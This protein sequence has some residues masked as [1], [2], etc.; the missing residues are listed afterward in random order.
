MYPINEKRKNRDV[1]H[2]TSYPLLNP[3]GP[4]SDQY[5]YVAK[6]NGYES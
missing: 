6:R 3:L 2:K 4:N 1:I 5:P